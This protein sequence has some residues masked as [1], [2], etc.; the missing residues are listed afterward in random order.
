MT[1]EATA[2]TRDASVVVSEPPAPRDLLGVACGLVALVVYVLHGFGGELSKDSAVYVY[3]GQRFADGVLPY[4]D[5]VNRAGP[6]A[7]AI[8][9][10]A[11]WVTRLVGGDDVYGVRVLFML[12]SAGCIVA[13][14]HLGRDLFASRAAGLAAAASLLCSQGFILYATYGPREKT[15]MVLFLTL[16]LLAVVHQRWFTAGVLVSLATLV[17]QPVL[18]AALAGIVVAIAV[19][20]PARRWWRALARVAVGGALPALVTLVVYAIAGEVRILID[21]FLLINAR[22]TRQA[23]FLDHPAESWHRLVDGYGVTLWLFIGGLVAVVALAAVALGK[24]ETRRAPRSAG[25][26]GT[27]VCTVGGV[28]WTMRAYDNWP[29]VM[30]L[31]PCAAVGMGGVVAGFG[32]RLS[33]TASHVVTAVFCVVCL[34]LAVVYSVAERSTVLDDQRASVEAVQKVLPHAEVFSVEAPQAMVLGGWRNASRYQLF[35][36]GLIDYVDATWPGGIEGYGRWIDRQRPTVIAAPK[37]PIPDWLAPTLERSYERAGPAP[38]WEWYV[39]TDV[40]EH[41]RRMLERALQE[42]ADGVSG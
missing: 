24:G 20:L 17:W 10:V 25:L 23:G 31:L 39:R 26:V 2:P 1:E 8:P 40:P 13:V 4:V 5:L 34:N 7:H 28:L 9:G 29:D 18:F 42:A 21:C 36:N 33:A 27:A 37:G 15:A 14:Y 32:R 38:R 35:G 3:G 12:I 41:D 11:I 16:A 30:L 6:L 22:Y 19:G